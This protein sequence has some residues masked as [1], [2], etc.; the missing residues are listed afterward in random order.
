RAPGLVWDEAIFVTLAALFVWWM[1]KRLRHPTLRDSAWLGLASGAL[2]LLN[3]GLVLALPFGWL[4]ALRAKSV[5]WKRLSLHALLF[6][7]MT[8]VGSAPWHIRNWFLI[9]PPAYVF[10]RGPFWVATWT[11][12]H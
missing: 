6:V 4:A 3:P 11:S 1:L 2:A 9:H 7:T 12:M 8:F 5:R 10:I